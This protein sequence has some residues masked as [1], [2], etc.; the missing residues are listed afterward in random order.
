MARTFKRKEPMAAVSEINVTPLIDLAFALLIIFMITAPLLEQSIDINLPVETA[1]PQGS[2]EET[3]ETIA[4]DE[5]GRVFWGDK[6]V[7]RDQLELELQFIASQGDQP[8]ISIYA[9]STL[10]YQRVVDVVDLVKKYKL[11]KLSLKTRGQ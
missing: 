10:P 4:I 9:D 6:P 3:V 2:S 8:V 1:R 11:S 7:S 5:Q